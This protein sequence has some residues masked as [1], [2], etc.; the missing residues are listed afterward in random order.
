MN[1]LTEFKFKW[2]TVRSPDDISECIENCISLDDARFL[3]IALANN[4]TKGDSDQ[5]HIRSGCLLVSKMSRGSNKF[6]D[7]AVT[8]LY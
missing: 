8:Q 4:L 5:R 3:I 2:L 7:E 1:N 6:I